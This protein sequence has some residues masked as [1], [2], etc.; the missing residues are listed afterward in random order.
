MG[1]RTVR[2]SMAGHQRVADTQAGGGRADTPAGGG[3]VDIPAPGGRR[4]G[5]R[6]TTDGHTCLRYGGKGGH[7]GSPNTEAG[8]MYQHTECYE[9]H[10]ANVTLALQR[11]AAV[12]RALFRLPAGADDE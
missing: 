11:A 4:T 2:P 7:G 5:G 3:Q 9:L 1:V 8:K 12:R 6:Y 10:Q